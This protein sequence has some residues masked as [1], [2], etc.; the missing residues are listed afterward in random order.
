MNPPV[1]PSPAASSLPSLASILSGWDGYQ[2][3]L[4]RAISPLS[5]EQLAFRPVPERRSVGE[6]AGHIA[7][8]RVDWF[9][10][11][12]APGSAELA[13]Q[14]GPFWDTGA[15]PEAAIGSRATDIVDWLEKS[16]AMVEAN[17]SRWTPEDLTWTYHQPY[18]GKVYAVSRQW[19]VFR[20]LAHDIHHGGQLTTLLSLQGIDP[21]DLSG[22]G[23]HI[24]Q[25]PQVPE[26]NGV[27]EQAPRNRD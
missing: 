20:L 4:V 2:T 5:S 16:W 3:S 10:R 23:G 25:V 22:Q 17:L 18:Q 15:R 21:P 24:A 11:M 13:Q 26:G 6:T 14:A 27:T 1:P 19:V 8:G 12:N 7:L 9:S